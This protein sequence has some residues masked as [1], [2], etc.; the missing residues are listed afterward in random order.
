MRRLLIALAVF[1]Y[2]SGKK[3]EHKREEKMA[4]RSPPVFTQ[5][6]FLLLCFRFLFDELKKK[7]PLVV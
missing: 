6:L 4:M 3:R 7:R 2:S 1:S 5:P